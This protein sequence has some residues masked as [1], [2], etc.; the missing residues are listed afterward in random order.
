MLKFN[1]LELHKP[2]FSLPYACLL[3]LRILCTARYPPRLSS[4]VHPARHPLL[5]LLS[6]FFA[7]CLITTDRP[8]SCILHSLQSPGPLSGPL[9]FHQMLDILFVMGSV[10]LSP[11]MMGAS[12]FCFC[13]VCVLK[14]SPPSLPVLC[15]LFSYYI[16]F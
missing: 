9:D 14:S 4:C 6:D 3:H 11:T 2:T 5:H 1:F 13:F 10:L 7:P 16:F 12:K 8:C 15:Y